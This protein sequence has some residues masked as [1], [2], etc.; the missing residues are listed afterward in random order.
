M[1]SKNTKYFGN[2]TRLIRGIGGLRLHYIPDAPKKS[3]RNGILILQVFALNIV[4]TFVIVS[5]PT[6]NVNKS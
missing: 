5:V 2:T 4:K 1:E 3:L 6:P